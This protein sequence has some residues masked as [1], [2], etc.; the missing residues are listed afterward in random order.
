MD[1][2]AAL[3]RAR[4]AL[5]DAGRTDAVAEAHARGHMTA[6][7]RIA[8]LVDPGSFVEHG[9]FARPAMPGLDGPADGIIV[10]AGTIGGRPCAVVSY[11]YSVHAGTQ[12]VV[13]HAKL[14]HILELARKHRWPMVV[15]AEGAGA[16][17]QEMGL[18]N[19]GRRVMSF[20][21]LAKLSGVVPLIAIVPG[22]SFGG[23]AALAG[24]CDIIV[25]TPDAAMGIAGP[26]FVKVSTGQDLTA[27]Q[28][29]PA[30]LHEEVGAVDVLARDDADAI[31]VARA[32]FELTSWSLVASEAPRVDPISLRSAVPTSSRH[33]YDVRTVLAGVVDAGSD[34]ELRPRWAAN[35]VTVLARID[36]R[37][38][39]IVANNPAVLAGAMD[40]DA[41]DKMAR[42]VQLC[43]VHRIPIVFLAD[44]P[45]FLVGPDAERSALVR[46]S[47]RPILA[48]AHATVPIMLVVLRKAYGL[49]YFSMGTRPF[50]PVLMV[51]WPTAEF[52]S[53]GHAGAAAIS[54]ADEAELRADHATS[55]F[56]A[57]F[58]VDD[59]IDPTSTRQLLADTLRLVPPESYAEPSPT[60]PLDA[61]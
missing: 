54:G 24:L 42:F 55:T 21:G 6:R 35:M 15:F 45:G 36:G 30:S 14:D 1:D 8:A 26:P 27:D 22:R 13:S 17:A 4:A 56:A 23:H 7:E 61:W 51:A 20:A 48:L 32:Y 39:G 40:R 2:V 46:H 53:M 5:G 44:T 9:A 37:S 31:D 60:R 47:S 25:A 41:S 28:L 33:A 16:R 10:G 29:G 52:G 34:L 50:D 3:E 18:G 43:D 12:G 49:G 19:Y 57:K 59:V 38:V 58:A 11:D